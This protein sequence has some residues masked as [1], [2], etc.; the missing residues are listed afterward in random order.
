MH[1]LVV[2]LIHTKSIIELFWTQLIPY[3]IKIHVDQG[4]THDEAGSGEIVT[5]VDLEDQ[6]EYAYTI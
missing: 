5:V 3:V 4:L 1:S 2:G 6:S